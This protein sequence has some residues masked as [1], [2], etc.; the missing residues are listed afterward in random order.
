MSF[1]ATCLL[2]CASHARAMKLAPETHSYYDGLA[3]M[4]AMLLIAEGC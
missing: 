2:L 4:Y 3:R 1:H